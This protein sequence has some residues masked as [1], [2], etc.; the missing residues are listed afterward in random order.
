MAVLIAGLVI[1]LGVH[2]I[3]IIA[4]QAR[5]AA[6]RRFG[7]GAWKAGYALLSLAG[8]ALL[9]MAAHWQRRLAISKAPEIVRG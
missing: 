8:F 5:D 4:P 7:A 2:S 3:A 1:F 9:I 6:L